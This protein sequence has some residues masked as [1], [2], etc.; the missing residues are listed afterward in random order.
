LLNQESTFNDFQGGDVEAEYG[1]YL[2]K[3][4]IGTPSVETVA[5]VDL[6]NELVLT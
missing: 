6:A 1:E 5:I 4:S 2:A 3:F